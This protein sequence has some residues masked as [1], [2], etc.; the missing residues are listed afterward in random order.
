[1]DTKPFTNAAL[2]YFRHNISE[3]NN[4]IAMDSLLFKEQKLKTYYLNIQ[5]HQLRMNKTNFLTN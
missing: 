4:N 2:S 5:F 3:I 1:M